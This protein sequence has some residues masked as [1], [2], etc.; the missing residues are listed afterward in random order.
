MRKNAPI[1]SSLRGINH[2]QQQ[3]SA[4]LRFS[5]GMGIRP[6]TSDKTRRSCDNSSKQE[7]KEACFQ[8]VHDPQACPAMFAQADSTETIPPSIFSMTLNSTLTPHTALL[9]CAPCLRFLTRFYVQG[10]PSNVFH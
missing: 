2:P 10:G 1:T 4:V 5:L 8:M 6:E 7:R 3:N 9:S